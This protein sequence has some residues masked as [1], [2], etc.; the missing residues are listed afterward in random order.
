MILYTMNG[1]HKP[2]N[3]KSIIC[4]VKYKCIELLDLSI[5]VYYWSG[6]KYSI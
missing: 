4:H 5:A 2:Y 3:N 1:K 6:I